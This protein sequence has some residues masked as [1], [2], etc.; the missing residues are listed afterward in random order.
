VAGFRCRL[1]VAGFRR[2][3]F[4]G[5]FPI[6][7][8]LS[9]PRM[10]GQVSDG[11]FTEGGFAGF[12][13]AGSFR[14]DGGFG[15]FWGWV[16]G[17]TGFRSDGVFRDAGFRGGEVSGRGSPSGF[18]CRCRGFREWFQGQVFGSRFFKVRFS[19]RDL[20]IRFYQ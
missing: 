2:Q 14:V 20:P 12:R 19:Y 5:G 16:F 8:S 1:S 3:V 10:Q 9:V 15:F 17:R 18:P 4:R 11:R 7:V 6:G 13:V